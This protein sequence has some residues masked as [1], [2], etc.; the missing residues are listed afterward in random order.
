[1]ISGS[2]AFSRM[3]SASSM[4]AAL[5]P[6]RP[7]PILR[8]R[9]SEQ[10][11]DREPFLGD[12]DVAQLVADQGADEHHLGFFQARFQRRAFS[13]GHAF[14]GESLLENQLQRGQ[15]WV[16]REGQ[17]AKTDPALAQHFPD[18]RLEQFVGEVLA[19]EQIGELVAHARQAHLPQIGWLLHRRDCAA[20]PIPGI[21]MAI[22]RDLS[23]EL[24]LGDH[25]ALEEL[26]AH[27][28]ANAAAE[29]GILAQRKVNAELTT[30][31]RACLGHIEIYDQK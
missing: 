20:L 6:M 7:V 4:P 19:E 18:Q 22:W 12:V 16:D 15:L 30:G 26:A 17:L 2:P 31:V 3:R 9:I 5:P 25:P 24:S 1:M 29:D 11:G 27:A 13:R 28:R 23:L 14:D 8:R 21:W 10:V